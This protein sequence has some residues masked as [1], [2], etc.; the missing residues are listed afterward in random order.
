M[1]NRRSSGL[2]FNGYGFYQ[3]SS[4]KGF[5]RYKS[6]LVYLT[7]QSVPTTFFSSQFGA[8]KRK[9]FENLTQQF[10]IKNRLQ[11]LVLFAVEDYQFNHRKFSMSFFGV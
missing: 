10:E 3:L 11:T 2:S 6:A 7:K 5:L 9:T 1:Y 4:G 8:P